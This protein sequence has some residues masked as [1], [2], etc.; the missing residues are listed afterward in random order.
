[1]VD[2]SHISLTEVVS[3]LQT[4]WDASSLELTKRTGQLVDIASSTYQMAKE[5]DPTGALDRFETSLGQLL[6]LGKSLINKETAGAITAIVSYKAFSRYMGWG[7]TEK[8]PLPIHAIERTLPSTNPVRQLIELANRNVSTYSNATHGRY[9]GEDRS[10]S[11]VNVFFIPETGSYARVFENAEGERFAA[12]SQ[13]DGIFRQ[14]AGQKD[15]GSVSKIDYFVSLGNT[16]DWHGALKVAARR[17]RDHIIV[18]EIAKT[19][20]I[21]SNQL[22][23]ITATVGTKIVQKGNKFVVHTFHNFEGGYSPIQF[24]KAKKGRQI[25]V[26]NLETA[27]KSAAAYVYATQKLEGQGKDIRSNL[28]YL[29]G[30]ASTIGNEIIDATDEALGG[31]LRSPTA[32]HFV[33][34]GAK[35]ILNPMKIGENLKEVWQNKLIGG[36][37]NMFG[38]LTFPEHTATLGTHF[39]SLSV[40]GVRNGVL[41]REGNA[42]AIQTA[43]DNGTLTQVT[44]GPENLVILD[45]S[46]AR[47]ATRQRAFDFV[48]AA[49]VAPTH[50]TLSRTHA[51]WEITNPAGVQLGINLVGAHQDTVALLRQNAGVLDFLP[52]EGKVGNL[53]KEL[54][55]TTDAEEHYPTA[56]RALTDS[57]LAMAVANVANQHWARRCEIDLENGYDKRGTFR[58]I[59][60]SK[61]ENQA[62]WAKNKGKGEPYVSVQKPIDRAGKAT[63]TEAIPHVNLKLFD[64]QDMPVEWRDGNIRAVEANIYDI[65]SKSDRERAIAD[66]EAWRNSLPPERKGDEDNIPFEQLERERPE[67]AKRALGNAIAIR[68]ALQNAL[69]QQPGTGIRGV[70]VQFDATRRTAQGVDRDMLERQGEIKVIGGLPQ[71]N[72]ISLDDARLKSSA[73]PAPR[74]KGPTNVVSLVA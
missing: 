40:P 46:D 31:V 49:T 60:M 15:T 36:A 4:F 63:G 22:E 23:I 25:I 64:V 56:V 14:Q 74:G 9:L 65:L 26:D 61:P 1:M 32:A 28:Q 12:F 55:I 48:A 13:T 50:G 67:S 62:W 27:Q 8:V 57:P 52:R 73:K 3:S 71:A 34:R 43:I 20:A 11:A 24:K 70:V 58:K 17:I 5:N 51:G 54:G 29:A 59:D 30:L 21:N 2:F 69:K 19:T 53:L 16:E 44:K 41:I 7:S 72:V 39:S 10:G 38:K 33:Y 18:P 47:S 37:L 45:V 6:G 66:H 42:A 35:A 68:E